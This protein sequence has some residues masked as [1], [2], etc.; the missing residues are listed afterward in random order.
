MK[1]Y[2]IFFLNPQKFFFLQCTQRE[3]VHNGKGS[4][5]RPN[6]LVEYKW[7]V[8]SAGCHNDARMNISIAITAARHGASIAN[9]VKVVDLIKVGFTGLHKNTIY[10]ISQMLNT[11]II[12]SDNL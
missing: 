8:Y 1:I 9:H 4:A 11:Y 6:S 3:H 10:S 12:A 5:K 2:E 7:S